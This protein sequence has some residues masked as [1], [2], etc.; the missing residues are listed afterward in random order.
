[1]PM[2]INRSILEVTFWSVGTNWIIK[3]NVRI[4]IFFIGLNKLEDAMAL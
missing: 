4:A 3:K 2:Q 1:M